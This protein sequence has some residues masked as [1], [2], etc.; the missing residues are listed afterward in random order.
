MN[1]PIPIGAVASRLLLQTITD[2]T[3]LTRQA[4]T[5]GPGDIEHIKEQFGLLTTL[6]ESAVIEL[7]KKLGENLPMNV[8]IDMGDFNSG[9]ADARQS[10]VGQLTNMEDMGR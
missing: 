1:N 8:Q 10:I 4:R 7:M 9:L 3:P 5:A 6:Y 2:K